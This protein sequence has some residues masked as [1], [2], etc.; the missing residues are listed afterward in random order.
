LSVWCS[1]TFSSCSAAF[2]LAAHHEP[3]GYLRC[4]R[5]RSPS[6]PLGRF[7]DLRSCSS[8]VLK[9]GRAVGE[10]RAFLSLLQ[11]VAGMLFVILLAVFLSERAAA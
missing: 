11:P 6:Y 9:E 10:I 3:L 1:G 5:S 2:F 8:L 7:P 4:W